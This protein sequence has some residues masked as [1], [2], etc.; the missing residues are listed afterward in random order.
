M[1]VGPVALALYHQLASEKIL[2]KGSS[3]CEI[4]SQD[5]VAAGFEGLVARLFKSL[6]EPAPDTKV[7]WGMARGSSR[8]L[9]QALGIKYACI[10][11]DGRHD[12]TIFI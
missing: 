7:L 8:D 1:G 12:A 2:R 3:V 5:V 4:G 9:M 10:D 11:T 6:D